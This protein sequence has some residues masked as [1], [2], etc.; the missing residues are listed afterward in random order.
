MN[1]Y[2]PPASTPRKT[3]SGCLIALLV[4]TGL[5]IIAVWVL[6]RY[7]V[8]ETAPPAQ[9]YVAAN[10]TN[11]APADEGRNVDGRNVDGKI[12]PTPSVA[13][14]AWLS[15]IP[16]QVDQSPLPEGA[17]AD[18]E[19]LF[20]TV[21]PVQ[22]YFQTAEELG[23]LE[24]GERQS[25]APA[26]QVGDRRT[27][28]T[29]DGP[30]EAE[31]LLVTDNGYYWAETGMA[32]DMTRMKADVEQ[33]ESQ[34]LPMLRDVFG[35]EWSP[36]MDGDPRYSV[37]HTLGSPDVHELGYFTDEN[38]Y[39]RS[40]FVESNETEVVFLNM[41]Q[42]T[43]GTPLYLGTLVH[44]LQHLIQWNLDANE[45][46]WMNEGLSQLAETMAG[47]ATVD[48]EAHAEQPDV[49]L[50]RWDDDPAVV[51]AHYAAS[52]LFL[53]YLWEQAGEGAVR[54]LARQPADGLPAVRD[55]LGGYLP[56]R[57][58]ESFAADWA[59]ANYLDD[60]SAGPAY[61]YEK[62]DLSPPFLRSRMRQLPATFAGVLEPY[63]VDYIDLDFSG[64]AIIRFAGDTRAALYDPW[65]D[66]ATD[67]WYAPP[68]NSSRA[69]LTAALDLTGLSSASL[70]FDVWY[71]LEAD[72]DY[73]YLTV[74]TDG[75]Q[76]WDVLRPDHAANGSYGPAFNGRS[77]EE[78]ADT[79]GWLPGQVPLD[80]YAGQQVLVRFEVVTDFEGL[81]RGFAVKNAVVPG[82]SAAGQ[83][84]DWQP[85]GFVQAGPVLPQQWAARL[86]VEGK[87][88]QVI[89][90]QLDALN[91][92]Q[93]RVELGPEGGVLVV[94]PLT[95]FTDETA[96]YW[97]EVSAE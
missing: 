10:A 42:L 34:Y 87:P 12:V 95:P 16:P 32:L 28:Y 62:L 45:E 15:D 80:A 14:E 72:W 57:T 66:A 76:T 22:D 31:L 4:V 46:V 97:V 36:G 64:P 81:G 51:S 96:D 30:R 17:A 61:S 18:L 6:D 65:A 3:R 21:A 39:P 85:A 5:A 82:P 44:E 90:I 70:V 93:A 88:P 67:V 24:L 78:A 13:S 47:L 77:A 60:P 20:D 53:H 56:D 2:P 91:R 83:A 73:A 41:S 43:V 94:M 49:R 26:H 54:E 35:R 25:V 23:G 86:I 84:I 89:P 8:D 29:A 79:N 11:T 50:D 37:L 33:L 52:Y 1:P 58:L 55:V 7:T 59:V 75:G 40:L 92:G 48:V 19:R 74:S 71:D 38:E 63:A 9:G 68:A 27:F 69:Q